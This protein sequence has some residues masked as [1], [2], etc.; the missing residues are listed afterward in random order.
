MQD[1]RD[2]IGSQTVQDE[3][4]NVGSK[5]AQEESVAKQP[6]QS[7]LVTPK[8][9]IKMKARRGS[10]RSGTREETMVKVKETDVGGGPEDVS[11]T[12][13]E[14]I[15]G[16]LINTPYFEVKEPEVEVKEHEVE[17]KENEAVDMV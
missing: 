9:R 12:C 17:E 2:N 16:I 1:E 6:T 3:G 10:K 7:I 13:E 15:N 8:K 4:D 14:F 5:T 11:H